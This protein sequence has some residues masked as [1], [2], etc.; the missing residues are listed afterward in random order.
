MKPYVYGSANPIT[1]SDPSGLETCGVDSNGNPTVCFDDYEFFVTEQAAKV[2]AHAIA[3]Y[4]QFRLAARISPFMDD[5][6][7]SL[8][9]RAPCGL[10]HEAGWRMWVEAVRKSE[11]PGQFGRVVRLIVKSALVRLA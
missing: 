9:R 3:S 1:Y 5:V 4:D 7:N 2:G 10:S 8:R 11:R 6:W